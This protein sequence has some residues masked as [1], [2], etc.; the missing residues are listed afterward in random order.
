MWFGCADDEFALRRLGAKNFG[1]ATQPRG[2]AGQAAAWHPDV[3]AIG[4]R[5]PSPDDAWEFLQYLVDP[6]TQRLELDQ[7]LWLPQA[8]A[9]TD[10]AEYRAP[11][12]S[13][14]DR[15]ASIAG[16]LVK[17]RSPVVGPSTGAMRRAARAALQAFWQGSM[18]LDRAVTGAQEAS[19][20]ALEG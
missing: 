11:P 2:R 9:I 13:P 10:E 4:A 3:V 14:R 18:S 12:L 8:K 5:A 20:A 15:R 6:D 7:A 19:L 16:A 17:A 1:F